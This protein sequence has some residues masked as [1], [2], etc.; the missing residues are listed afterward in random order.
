MSLVWP[1][2]TKFSHFSGKG[3]TEARGGVCLF[4]WFNF[5]LGLGGDRLKET[6]IKDEDS[7]GS[8][9]LVDFSFPLALAVLLHLLRLIYTLVQMDK[10]YF[11]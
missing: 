9:S 4:I 1:L 2:N 7:R 6:Q 3:A 8:I 11:Y 5:V 10:A